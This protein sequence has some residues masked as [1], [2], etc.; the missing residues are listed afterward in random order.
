MLNT[1]I[2]GASGY[3]GAELAK[4]VSRHPQLTLCGLYVSATSL[5][6]GKPLSDLHG[7]LR[8]VVDLPL[9]PLTD[10]KTAAAKS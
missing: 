1:V 8:D 9:Q 2:V 6:A 5:D 3:T 7:Q 10:I 4:I